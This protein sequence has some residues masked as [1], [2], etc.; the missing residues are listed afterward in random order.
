MLESKRR[1]YEARRNAYIGVIGVAILWAILQGA[2]SFMPQSVKGISG[3]VFLAFSFAVAGT[4]GL[5]GTMRRDRTIVHFMQRPAPRLLI[6]R[7]LIADIIFSSPFLLIALATQAVTHDLIELLPASIAL[8][9]AVYGAALPLAWFWAC[10]ALTASDVSAIGSG[11]MFIA[12]VVSGFLIFFFSGPLSMLRDGTALTEAASSSFVWLGVAVIG[13]WLAA[14]A[15]AELLL[16]WWKQ[17]GD[18]FA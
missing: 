5:I 8:G 4:A 11:G 16:Y 17:G 6:F 7:V 2:G 10:H 18:I 13:V 12:A 9:C 15:V 14:F 1:W 3:V